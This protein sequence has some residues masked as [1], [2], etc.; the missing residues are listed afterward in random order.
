MFITIMMMEKH[1][2]DKKYNN[3]NRKNIVYNNKSICEQWLRSATLLLN[4]T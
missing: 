4:L 1:I 2:V 3:N